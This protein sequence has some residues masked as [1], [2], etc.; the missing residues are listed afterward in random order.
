MNKFL[1]YGLFGLAAIALFFGV[2]VGVA[3][4]TGAPMHEVAV[5]G[6]L[7]EAPAEDANANNMPMVAEQNSGDAAQDG[8]DALLRQAGLLGAFTMPSPFSGGE[9]RTLETELRAKF[10]E[11]RDLA[12]RLRARELELDNEEKEFR[13]KYEELADLRTKLEDLESSLELRFSELERD[14]AAKRGR[15]L[16]GWKKQAELYAGG[17]PEANARLLEMEAP[18][19]AATILSQL[20]PSEASAILQ[21]VTPITRRKE[22]MDAYRKAN[23]TP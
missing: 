3:A 14:E 8:R 11:N 20:D 23:E 16:A 12:E 1:K 19:D 6:S 4:L 10:R 9:L 17:E 13:E 5:I 21:Q 18:E 2:F 15:E 22:F 7:F